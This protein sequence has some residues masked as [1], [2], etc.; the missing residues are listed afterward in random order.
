M[1]PHILKEAVDRFLKN[2]QRDHNSLSPST[3]LFPEDLEKLKELALMS[4]Q[5]HL[6]LSV[7][8]QDGSLTSQDKRGEGLESVGA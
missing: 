6:G 5:V 3:E 8:D 1:E 7:V 4:L 2:F